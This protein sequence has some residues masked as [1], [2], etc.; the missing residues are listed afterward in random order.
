MS[1]KLNLNFDPKKSNLKKRKLFSIKQK[2]YRKT[3][4]KVPWSIRFFLEVTTS[5]K[6]I[7]DIESWY[8]HRFPTNVP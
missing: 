3:C 7:S 5:N 6:N 8:C 4:F 1:K 2:N